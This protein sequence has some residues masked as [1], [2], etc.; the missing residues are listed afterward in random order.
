M[1]SPNTPDLME[2]CK[3]MHKTIKKMDKVL[4]GCIPVEA[5]ITKVVTKSKKYDDK[6]SSKKEEEPA[7]PKVVGS[8]TSSTK[9]GRLPKLDLTP[10]IEAANNEEVDEKPAPKRRGRPPKKFAMI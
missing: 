9:R 1:E 8:S 3:K 10:L 6:K 4:S 5:P 7:A 2:T